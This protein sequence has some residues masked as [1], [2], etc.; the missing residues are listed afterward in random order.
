MGQIS[1]EQCLESS[2]QGQFL[3]G[4]DIEEIANRGI[5]VGQDQRFF[6]PCLNDTT[7]FQVRAN[8]REDL[9]KHLDA[10][11]LTPEDKSKIF[12]LFE[13]NKMSHAEIRDKCIAIR[14]YMVNVFDIWSDSSMKS[15]TLTS[16][17][18]AIGH[19]NLKRLVGEFASLAIWIN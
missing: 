6:I 4:F 3:K 15:F 10:N 17:G 5:S 1:L 16:V 2:Y 18:M 14:P 12:D 7:K 11:G 9:E 13:L 8:N 19:A